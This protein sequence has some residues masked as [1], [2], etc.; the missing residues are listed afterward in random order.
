MDVDVDVEAAPFSKKLLMMPK[1][2]H[3]L[4]LEEK[5][6]LLAVER[7]DLAN[8]RRMLHKAHRKDGYIDIN[9]MDSLEGAPS[10]SP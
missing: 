6:F 9:C 1:L 10:P 8:V 5:K 2:P 3:I 7:G 4:S